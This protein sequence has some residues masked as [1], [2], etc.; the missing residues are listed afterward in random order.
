MAIP[1]CLQLSM[2]NIESDIL[3]SVAAELL[4]NVKKKIIKHAY[5]GERML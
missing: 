2:L 3:F 4:K 1:Q 5:V